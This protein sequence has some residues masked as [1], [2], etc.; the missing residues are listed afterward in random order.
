MRSSYYSSTPADD[1]SAFIFFPTGN[2]NNQWHVVF[3]LPNNWT[4]SIYASSIEEQL[5]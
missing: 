2:A 1:I 5:H 3:L 4:Y